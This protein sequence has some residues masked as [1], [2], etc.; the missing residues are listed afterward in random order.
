MTLGRA[1]VPRIKVTAYCEVAECAKPALARGLCS[2]HYK[3]LRRTGIA[4]MVKTERGM[5][6][7]SSWARLRE[8]FF[9]LYDCDDRDELAYERADNRCHQAARE[10]V[11]S[12][13]A[14]RK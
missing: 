9:A 3:R 12:R 4:T 13:L 7:E 6:F 10:W 14:K 8:A 2:M 5:R 11:G 1:H